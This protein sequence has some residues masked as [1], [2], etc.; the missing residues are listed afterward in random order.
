MCGRWWV[1]LEPEHPG[2]READQVRSIEHDTLAEMGLTWLAA[3]CGSFRGASEVQV[4]PQYVADGACLA[5]MYH[6]EFRSRC[7]GWGLSPKT[8]V[9][10]IS[11]GDGPCTKR[12][13]GDIPDYFSCVFE[14]KATRADFLSTFGGRDNDHKNRA[15]P[16]AHLHWVVTERGVCEPGEVPG[17]WGLLVRRG[18]GLSEKK[19]PG[20][21][22]RTELDVLRL[23]DRLVWKP[24]SRTRLLLPNCPNCNGP[25]E[26]RRPVSF[27]AI[28]PA[29]LMDDDP[30]RQKGDD[31]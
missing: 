9:Y 6:S 10:D 15:E 21:I 13:K 24:G 31:E 19:R 18:R 11:D 17:H 1:R 28:E 20:Y 4:A 5:V 30:S 12:E 23:A 27:R 16:A 25:L 14:A 26:Q 29:H 2:K 22:A 7:E 3:R 8:I